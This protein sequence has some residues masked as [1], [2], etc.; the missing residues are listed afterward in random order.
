[1]IFICF[2]NSTNRLLSNSCPPSV[3]HMHRWTGSALVQVK[4][5]RLFGNCAIRNKLHWNLIG[6]Q[7]FSFKNMCLNIS[8]RNFP[9]GDL[10]IYL[11]S[12]LIWYVWYVMQ[13]KRWWPYLGHKTNSQFNRVYHNTLPPYAASRWLCYL[14]IAIPTSQGMPTNMIEIPICYWSHRQ[15]VLSTYSVGGYYPAPL[16]LLFYHDDYQDYWDVYVNGYPIWTTDTVFLKLYHFRSAI[17]QMPRCFCRR[18]FL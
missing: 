14:F 1:M 11:T 5:Y 10:L 8:Q 3:A 16:A 7:S 9:S 6:I 13:A 2:I 18:T 4:A 17:A 12:R 15:N